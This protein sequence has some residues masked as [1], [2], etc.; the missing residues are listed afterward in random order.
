MLGVAVL[1]PMTCR[2]FSRGQLAVQ[3]LTNAFEGW[4]EDLLDS[5]CKDDNLR[6]ARFGEVFCSTVKWFSKSSNGSFAC[7][8]FSCKEMPRSFFCRTRLPDID[9]NVIQFSSIFAASCALFWVRICWI[10]YPPSPVP[11]MLLLDCM[12]ELF[13]ADFGSFS[14]WWNSHGGGQWFEFVQYMMCEA[15]DCSVVFGAE[16]CKTCWN[17]V[18]VFLCVSF[19]LRSMWTVLLM[20]V[21]NETDKV[22]SV[23]EVPSRAY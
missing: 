5:I 20:Q 8:G 7:T 21:E 2:V 11:F 9:T 17:F 1:S 14:H 16:G 18:T 6:R 3:H 4:L 15:F 19:A 13:A 12:F 23:L 22:Q 10:W